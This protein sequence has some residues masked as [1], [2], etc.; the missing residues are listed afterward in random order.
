[1]DSRN[2]R[3]LRAYSW[4]EIFLGTR[5]QRITV[6]HLRKLPRLMKNQNGDGFC[7]RP[8]R[9]GCFSSGSTNR[10]GINS[11]DKQ[12]TET[13]LPAHRH[14]APGV[15]EVLE[16]RIIRTVLTTDNPFQHTPSVGLIR[17]GDE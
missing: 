17:D 9:N 10:V 15:A 11:G 6:S 12:R 3:N 8:M 4:R 1:M 14:K 13:V 7:T 16:P 2:S 5:S